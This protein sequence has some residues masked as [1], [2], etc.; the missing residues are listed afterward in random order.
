MSAVTAGVADIRRVVQ[1]A[2]AARRTGGRTVLFLDEIHRFSKA[3]QDTILPHV[4]RG[5]IRLIGATT[6]NPSFEVNAALLSRCQVVRLGALGPDE[7]RTIVRRAASDPERGLGALALDLLPEGEDALVAAAAGDA[8]TALG[9]LE[10]AAHAAAPGEGGRRAIDAAAVEGALLR[11]LPRHDRAGDAHYDTISAFIKSVRGSDADAG[12]YWL[13]RMLEA[14]EDPVFVAR[15]LV[16]LAAE[17]VGLADPQALP[18]AVAALSAVHA[19]GMPEAYL[20]LAEATLYLA[21]AD[22]SNSA[23]RAYGAAREAALGRPDAPV[24]LHLRNAPTALMRE[25]GYGE[26]YRYAHDFAGGVAGQR[27]LPDEVQGSSFYEPGGRGREA[28][29]ATRWQALRARI[30]ETDAGRSEGRPDDRRGG[31]GTG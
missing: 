13:A 7:V 24:P 11:R 10:V 2:A 14:G 15:R 3:Q 23:Y 26:G 5:T 22:K 12:V 25:A 18:L 29:M 8:R 31:L 21:L 4:E 9:A 28:E 1:E 16:L 20:P 6:E 30:H 17:D 27:Y 19:I